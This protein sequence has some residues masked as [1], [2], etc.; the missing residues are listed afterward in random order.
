M[1][2][3]QTRDELIAAGIAPERLPEEWKWR[4]D[5][6][7][8]DLRGAYL[9]GADLMNAD[10]RGADLRDAKINWNSHDLLAEIALRAAGDDLRQRMVAGLILISRDWCWN[11]FVAVLDDNAKNWLGSVFASYVK[12]GDDA[13]DIVRQYVGK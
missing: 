13:P 2:W 8:A 9:R 1:N 4:I 3:T 6:K 5:L 11:E 7:G 12:D 10:L